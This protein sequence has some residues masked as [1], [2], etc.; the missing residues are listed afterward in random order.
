MKAC[1]AADIHPI[2]VTG[3]HPLTARAV[4]TE[5][6]LGSPSPRVMSGDEVEEWVRTGRGKE[7]GALD[8][9][10]RAKPAQKLLLVRTLQEA[11]EIVAVTGDGVND[12]PALQAADIGVA[13]GEHAAPVRKLILDHLRFLGP[14]TALVIAANE[15]RMIAEHCLSVLKQEITP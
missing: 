9:I 12:V 7:L 15:E 5:V 11:G 2:M 6:G 8:V 4:A 10:A 3:D 1:Q 14:F 13:I